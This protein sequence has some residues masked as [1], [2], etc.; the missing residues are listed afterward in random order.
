MKDAPPQ[1]DMS[2]NYS[3]QRI[4]C[5]PFSRT[6]WNVGRLNGNG[7]GDLCAMRAKCA[8]NVRHVKVRCKSDL[9]LCATQMSTNMDFSPRRY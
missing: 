3:G 9:N 8:P 4:P 6:I 2:I 1:R 7:L 5:R